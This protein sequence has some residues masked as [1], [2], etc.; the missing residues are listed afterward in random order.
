MPSTKVT[1]PAGTPPTPHSPAP[2][3]DRA[4]AHLEQLKVRIADEINNYPP[5]I[6]ACDAQFNYLLEQRGM[7]AEELTRLEAARLQSLARRDGAQA[8]AA[9]IASSRF[10][11]EAAGRSIG[12]SG[13]A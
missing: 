6:P 13:Q 5:P 12:E 8:I 3:W 1:Q 4:R 11:D 7:I 9:F 2:A 10:I